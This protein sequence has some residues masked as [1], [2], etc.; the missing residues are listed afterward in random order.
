MRFD[1]DRLDPDDPFEI[2]DGN[3]PHLYKHLPRPAGRFVVVGIEDILD[4]YHYGNALFFPTDIGPAE[5]KM[6]GEV[7][8][9]ILVVPLA[10]PNSGDATKCRPIGLYEASWREKQ[11]YR[12][13]GE[14]YDV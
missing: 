8:G 13:G 2:D 9:L 1:P 5:W 4:L 3:R 12:M 11:E 7:P 6:M 10:P 14:I